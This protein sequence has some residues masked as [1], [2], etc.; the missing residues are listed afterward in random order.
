[1][2]RSGFPAPS[3]SVATEGILLNFRLKK[4]D[5]ITLQ[6]N[7]RRGGRRLR[8]RNHPESSHHGKRS[9]KPPTAQP[10]EGACDSP[11][12]GGGR[13]GHHPDDPHR[14]PAP[15]RKA[16]SACPGEGG[17][18]DPEGGPRAAAGGR[19]GRSLCDGVHQVAGR[20]PVD[21]HP[22]PRG[23]GC[24]EG[25]PALYDRPAAVRGGSQGGPGPARARHGARRQGGH[26]CPALCRAGRQ[27]F[28]QQR[29]VRTVPRQLRGAAGFGR[30]RPGRCRPSQTAAGIL[31]HQGPDGRPDRPAPGGRG[32]PDQGQRRQGRH[33]GDRPDHADLRGLCGPPAVSPADQDPHGPG[34]S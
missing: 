25:G 19:H 30:G 14:R 4:P 16:R 28:R 5:T 20:R 23:P 11:D 8:R 29:Q 31:L 24:Q 2:T 17:H 21:G 18:R 7:T 32:H 6:C 26:G 33:G 34:D 3:G 10:P 22:F 12:P 1:M 9:S 15:A 13:P 27:E